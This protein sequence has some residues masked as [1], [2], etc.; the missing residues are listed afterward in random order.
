MKENIDAWFHFFSSSSLMY[1]VRKC[2]CKLSIETNQL[3]KKHTTNFRCV[4]WQSMGNRLKS[5]FLK[6]SVGYNCRM[7]DWMKGKKVCIEVKH[8][9]GVAHQDLIRQ[10]LGF[11]FFFR[12]SRRAQSTKN[13]TAA[14]C[15]VICGISSRTCHQCKHKQ[16]RH[17]VIMSSRTAGKTTARVYPLKKKVRDERMSTFINK[18]DWQKISQNIPKVSCN[19]QFKA[20]RFT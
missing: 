2:V 19:F 16:H 9:D 5:E 20:L 11:D 6:A 10:P 17:P 4:V 12:V 15:A 8:A 1:M 7:V 3:F 13:F 18:Q 14:I